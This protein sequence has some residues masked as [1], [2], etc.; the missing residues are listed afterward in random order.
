MVFTNNKHKFFK[1]KKKKGL[2]FETSHHH[3]AYDQGSSK[4]GQEQKDF[5]I[6]RDSGDRGRVKTILQISYL[7]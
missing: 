1:K 3:K 5:K 2:N 6:R 4:W 7:F